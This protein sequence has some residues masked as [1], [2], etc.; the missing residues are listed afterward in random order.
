MARNP[1]PR[2]ASLPKPMAIC[3]QCAHAVLRSEMNE[4]LDEEHPGWQYEVIKKMGLHLVA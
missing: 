2:Y 1:A 4:H 3:D